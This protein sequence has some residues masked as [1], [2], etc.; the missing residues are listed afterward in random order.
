MEMGFGYAWDRSHAS[1]I[2]TGEI[3]FTIAGF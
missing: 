2:S 3:S 1:L